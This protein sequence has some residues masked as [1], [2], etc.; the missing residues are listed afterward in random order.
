MCI[1]DRVGGG[2]TGVIAG[3]G[4]GG[5]GLTRMSPAYGEDGAVRAWKTAAAAAETMSCRFYVDRMICGA[6]GGTAVAGVW[7]EYVGGCCCGA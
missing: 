4:V 2:S 6:V 7:A 5:V 1:R 3:G